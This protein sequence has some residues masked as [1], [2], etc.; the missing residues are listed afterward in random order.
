MDV[1]FAKGKISLEQLPARLVRTSS[2]VTEM[3]GEKIYI[4]E[5]TFD[6]DKISSESSLSSCSSP[7]SLD[8][9]PPNRSSSSSSRLPKFARSTRFN[10][11]VVQ[12]LH[13]SQPPESADI[14]FRDPP[15]TLMPYT[16]EDYI[17]YFPCMFEQSIEEGCD[18]RPLHNRTDE[19]C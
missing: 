15:S 5:I 10:K 9:S 13:Q 2:D 6:A 11:V 4:D 16:M 12:E 18:V 3:I 19:C 8:W 14:L 1:L 7:K 17:A